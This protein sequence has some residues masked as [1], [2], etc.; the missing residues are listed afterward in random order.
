MI[1]KNIFIYPYLFFSI[2]FSAETVS[3]RHLNS[4]DVENKLGQKV[5]SDIQI[6]SDKNELMYLDNIFHQGAPIVLVMAYY[7][8][9]M[10][11]SLVL[12]GLS[13]A[14][15]ETDLIPGDHYSLITVSIDPDEGPSLSKEKKANYINNYFK[16]VDSSDFLIFSTAN[17]DNINQL[18]KELGFIYSYDEKINQF[19]HPAI[20]YVL[21][22]EGIISKQ[23]FGINPTSN[24]LKL[25]IL[26]AQDNS[27]SSIFD[28]ILLYCYKYDPKAGNYTMVA[29]NVMKVAG[30]STIFIMGGFLSFFWIRE[31][32]V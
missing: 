7:Q 18:T 19:A 21:T 2:L 23:M 11:C 13:K 25:S 17:Q 5:S 27:V 9:P 1:K 6:L 20:V 12:N 4:I 24:D 8:C 29:S 28:K 14:L 30:A 31:R 26:S 22:D 3:D 15:V 16:N 10:L 32:I